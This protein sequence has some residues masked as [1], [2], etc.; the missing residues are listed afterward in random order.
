M[1]LYRILALLFLARSCRAG[2][3]VAVIIG[4]VGEVAGDLAAAGSTIA[5]AFGLAA[6][7][8]W[9]GEFVIV[10]GALY[11]GSAIVGAGALAGGAVGGGK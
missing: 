6:S 9:F 3:V 2:P 10:N 1:N 8:I 11:Y 4:A 7:E 5:G